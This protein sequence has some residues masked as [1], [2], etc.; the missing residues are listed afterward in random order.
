MPPPTLP[1]NVLLPLKMMGNLKA[2]MALVSLVGPREVLFRNMLRGGKEGGE[3]GREGG[4]GEGRKA[5]SLSSLFL[6]Q[7]SRKQS[8]MSHSQTQHTHTHAC[9]HAHTHTRTHS[10]ILKPHRKPHLVHMDQ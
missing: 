5:F 10:P 6:R 3:G 8:C 2:A 9:M 4:E 7:S 1:V